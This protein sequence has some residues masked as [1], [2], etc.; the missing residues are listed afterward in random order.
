M[1]IQAYAIMQQEQDCKQYDFSRDHKNV[2][3]KIFR[4]YADSLWEN[5]DVCPDQ[6]EQVIY[7]TRPKAD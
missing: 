1:S 2:R 3:Q 5:C 7:L 4:E 6:A